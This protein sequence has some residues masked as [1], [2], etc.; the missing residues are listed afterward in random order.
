[1]SRYIELFLN[2][3]RYERNYSIHTVDSYCLDLKQFEAF[4]NADPELNHAIECIDSDMARNWMA[5][6]LDK[7]Y[8]AT[9]VSRKLSSL[10]SFFRYL[11]K[12]NI[13]P[14][15][16]LRLI[17]SPKTKKPLPT[18]ICEKEMEDLL[19]QESDQSFESMRNYLMAE[20]FYNTGIRRAELIN[21]KDSDIDFESKLI[22]IHG[23]R[24]KQRL[25]PFA[26][27]LKRRMLEYVDIRTKEVPVMGLY[28]FTR[29][30][31]QQLSSSIVYTIITR[32]LS[33]IPELRQRSPHVLR[34]SFATNMLNNGAKLNAVK[35][36]LGHSSLSS[37]SIYTHTTFKELKKIYKAHP[38]A[39]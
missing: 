32:Y 33:R 4:L 38:R 5:E 27:G 28:F 13:L 7:G 31:G 6:L 8:L 18:F 26:G 21:I 39:K 2:Y 10:K 12:T 17:V 16:P 11:T 25:I 37:T 35:E 14:T 1:M 30:N 3:L 34:H 24:N 23:K 15:N 29:V 9:S 20:I 36:L 22:K 19:S